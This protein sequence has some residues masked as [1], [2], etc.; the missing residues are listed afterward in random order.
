MSRVYY[1]PATRAKLRDTI[2]DTVRAG[3]VFEQVTSCN[4]WAKIVVLAL[5]GR[6]VPFKV[7]QM[8]AGVKKITTQ[9]DVCPRCKGLGKC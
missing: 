1:S 9:V 4:V 7:L 2:D 6:G 8:G 5:T 3:D